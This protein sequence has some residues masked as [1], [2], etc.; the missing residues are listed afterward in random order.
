MRPAPFKGYRDQ[1]TDASLHGPFDGQIVDESTGEPIADAAVVAVWS[2]DHGDGFIGPAGSEVF[3]T[4]TDEAGRYRV[5]EAK[6]ALRG[7]TTR[8][9]RFE[10]VV[11]KRGYIAYRSNRKPDGS[12]RTDFTVRH[13]RIN[14]KKWR[15]SD[16]HVD[17]LVF[18]AAPRSIQ[19]LSYWEQ[20]LANLELFRQQGGEAEGLADAAAG[21]AGAA[22][23]T[24]AAGDPTPKK[25]MLLDASGVLSPDEVRARTGYAGEFTVGEP[26]D[27]KRTDFYHGVQLQA[28]G[29]EQAYDVIYRVWRS[30]PGGMEPVVDTIEETLPGVKPSG[31]VTEE[32]WVFET[33]GVYAV[34]FVDREADVGVLL[35][36]G[37]QQCADLDTAIIL[38]KWIQ[39][40]LDRLR[41]EE[42]PVPAEASEGETGAAKE[43]P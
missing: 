23:E 39:R 3:E 35:T 29:Q 8:L 17:H 41:D 1:V 32:T 15:Q 18:L 33:K 40:N 27:L 9:V 43:N 28:D 31:E 42:A 34:G 36:C 4:T 38:A 16:S 26:S 24:P 30:P 22:E 19:K 5:P 7:P 10:L 20:D 14:L 2:Y 25:Q 12:A 37:D 21:D 6:L 13:N 11:Y